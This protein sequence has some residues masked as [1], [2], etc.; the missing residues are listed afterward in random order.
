MKIEL[1]VKTPEIDNELTIIKSSINISND[2]IN[3][4]QNQQQSLL[5]QYDEI[6]PLLNTINKNQEQTLLMLQQL[7][8]QKESIFHKIYNRFKETV[9]TL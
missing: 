9:I 5:K 4:L 3:R 1:D 6:V 8:K 2:R 7:L